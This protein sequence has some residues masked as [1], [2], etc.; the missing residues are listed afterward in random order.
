MQLVLVVIVVMIGLNVSGCYMQ[1]ILDPNV[2]ASR[3]IDSAISEHA[4]VSHMVTIGDSKEK[5]LAILLPTQKGLPANARKHH[6]SVKKN[7]IL[8]EVYYM[9]TGRNPDGRTTDDEFTPYFFLDGKLVAIGWNAGN[10]LT[11]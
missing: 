9:R 5:V 3:R 2:R 8:M 4:D 6:E 10:L 11:D 7:G 1:G